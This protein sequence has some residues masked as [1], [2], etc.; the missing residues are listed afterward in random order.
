M[1]KRHYFEDTQLLK[2]KGAGLE[3]KF[4]NIIKAWF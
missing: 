3:I 4:E 2:G 1:L